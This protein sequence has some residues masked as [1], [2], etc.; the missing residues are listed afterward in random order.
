VPRR[1]IFFR[2]ALL[3]HLAS[4]PLSAGRL[5]PRGTDSPGLSGMWPA[6][7]SNLRAK[8]AHFVDCALNDDLD[9]EDIG[10]RRTDASK[11]SRAVE[12]TL[13]LPLWANDECRICRA[14]VCPLG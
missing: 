7:S 11:H 14:F 1:G 4:H 6:C 9:E 3:R 8:H 12:V 5:L 13:S 2:R 10:F